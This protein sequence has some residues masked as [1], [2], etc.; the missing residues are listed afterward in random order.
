MIRLMDDDRESLE[1][2]RMVL[3]QCQL[4]PTSWTL[5]LSLNSIPDTSVTEYMSTDCG[6]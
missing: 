2:Q 6:Y 1:E 3:L 5:M 4:L